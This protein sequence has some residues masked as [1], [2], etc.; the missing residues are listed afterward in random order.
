MK[1]T[2]IFLEIE[3]QFMSKTDFH[4]HDLENLYKIYI[5]PLDNPSP[6]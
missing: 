3:Y 6:I 5:N 2:V 4:Q 1:L